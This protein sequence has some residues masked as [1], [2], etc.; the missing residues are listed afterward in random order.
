MKCLR[1]KCIREVVGGSNYCDQHK[2]FPDIVMKYAGNLSLDQLE[3]RLALDQQT[4]LMPLVSFENAEDL[5]LF[6]FEGKES[7]DISPIILV[8]VKVGETPDVFKAEQLAKGRQFI[9]QGYV[10]VDNKK[11]QILAFR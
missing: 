9:F 8:Q 11:T 2:L 10:L 6:Y 1:E 7:Y 3:Q 4:S 5:N